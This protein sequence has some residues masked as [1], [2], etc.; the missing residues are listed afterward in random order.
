MTLREFEKERGG[1][2]GSKEA[3]K[4]KI[5]KENSCKSLWESEYGVLRIACFARKINFRANFRDA[6]RH[7]TVLGTADTDKDPADNGYPEKILLTVQK[8]TS[9]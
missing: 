9:F 8:M 5:A 1:R 6:I 2:V 3:R 4:C 7:Q